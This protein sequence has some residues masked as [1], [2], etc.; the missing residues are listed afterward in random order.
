V[1]L[2]NI[3]DRSRPDQLAGAARVLAGIGLGRDLS[4]H[5]GLPGGFNNG[6]TFAD[7]AGQRFNAADVLLA[8]QGR[9]RDDGM[10]VIRS[11]AIDGVDL[12]TL[13]RQHLAE[14]LVPARLR[15]AI[16]RLL[17]VNIVQIAESDDLETLLFA[18]L[19]LSKTDAPDP[20]GSQGDFVAGRSRATQHAARD[21]RGGG[22]S[23]G[24][25]EQ[26][27]TTEGLQGRGIIRLIH[28]PSYK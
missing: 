23:R 18:G 17:R 12:V 13:G 21:D 16:V 5:T 8:P 25:F 6:P 2:V 11:A 3:A 27:A 15:P 24:S 19:H 7:R 22:K 28:A 10:G 14:V 4:R 20:D 1:H 26:T 9:Q